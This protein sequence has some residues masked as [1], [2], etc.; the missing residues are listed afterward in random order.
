MPTSPAP[1][2]LNTARLVVSMALILLLIPEGALAEEGDGAATPFDYLEWRNIGPVNMSGRVA[3][4]EGVA[5]DPRIVYV[6]TASGGVWKTQDG[7]LSFKPIFDEQPIASIGDL[8]LAPS[9]PEVIYVG[10]GESNVRNSVSFG[11]GVYGSTDGGRSWTHL[12][13]D[14]T[15]HISR[16]L[17]HPRNPDLVYVGALG[18]IF[19]PNEERGVYRS[20]DGGTSW[21]K[22]LYLDDRH[23][24]AD[25]DIDPTN[26]NIL[27]ASMWHFQRRPWTMTSGSAE[28]G[29]YRSI[30]GGDTWEK[31]TEGLPKQMGRIGV[32][33]APSRPQVVYVIAESNE[34][35]LFRSEDRGASFRKVS[36]DVTI[37][38]R[39][40]YY[41]DLRV[42]PADENRIYAVASKLFRSIDGG[43]S[44][45]RISR[46][47]HIDFHSLWIDPQDPRRMWQG[48]DGGVAVSYDHGVTWEPVRNLPIAQFYQ[49]FAD[50]REP[51][52]Y[53]GGGLQDNGAW[54]GPSRTRE[55]AGI[56][57]DDWRM[58]SFGD[59][60]FVV[61]HPHQEELFISESQA[62]GILRTDMVTRRQIDISPQPRRNDGGPAAALEYRFNWNSP[63]IASPHDP[64]T[65][66]FAGNVVFKSEDFGDS[67]EVVSPDLTTDDPHK[68]GEAGGPVWPE[69]TTAE[70]HCT[71][72]SFA[73]SPA[74]PGVLWAGTDDGNLQISRDGGVSWSNVVG[75]VPGLPAHSPVS[76]VEPSRTAEGTAYAAFDRH[77]F[78]DFRPYIYRTTD[79][80]VTW[81]RLV[82][83]LPST[84]WVWVVREDPRRHELLYAGT[85][86]GLYVSSTGGRRWQRLHLGNLPTVAVHDVLI[87]PRE[88]DLLLGTH[89][90]GI[91]IFD[92]ATPIQE[93]DETIV[94]RPA[95]LFPVRAALRFPAQF[96][97]Y[98]LG[99]K[100]Y[101][102]PNPPAGAL[103][104]YYL[105]EKL[106]SANGDDEEEGAGATVA[107]EAEERIRIE[108]LNAEGE[109]I[110]TLKDVGKKA[111]LNRVAWG[112]C[113]DPPRPRTDAE[114]EPGDFSGPP[115]GPQV[116]PGTYTVRLTVDGQQHETSVEV[117]IDPLLKVSTEDLVAQFEVALKLHEW[118]SAVND[119]LRA[120]DVLQQQLEAR[121]AT[122]KNMHEEIPEELE[123]QWKAHE[124][125][126][127]EHIHVLARGE[128][129]PFWSQGPRLSDL[130]D[131]LFRNVDR[132]FA[133]PTAAQM[134]YFAELRGE[135]RDALAGLNRFLTE[136]APAFNAAL[137]RHRIPPLAVPEA[138]V[139]EEEK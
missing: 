91:W 4:V 86:L 74:Q 89:G 71:I 45:R 87:H 26:P 47:T 8:A 101:R 109:T 31:L 78:D 63:I 9:N 135:V 1:I 13:L 64:M 35:T 42:D 82:A 23:G 24:V 5:G 49:I 61:P 73:E 75:N 14:R 103:I 60:Y 76:H 124:E 43:A 129:K 57:S 79:F 134:D 137:E 123:T 99:D 30:D 56:L 53:V 128:E 136:A 85:E 48:Q 83:E 121:R 62:G 84:A 131:R 81:T 51:F 94:D 93:F 114:E 46:S 97:R 117:R 16:V 133:A 105:R 130:L 125:T 17:V 90:R 27:Y 98:G 34:G 126:I 19:A 88:N 58:M 12:G 10:T 120:L 40:F 44:F 37:V 139:P 55:P 69:N 132:A 20:G 122:L 68:Q 77:M 106:E 115:R 70:Y 111:G 18:H 15:R 107:T 113:Y 127:Q 108:I 104:T 6:G 96:T 65:V 110:R 112:L 7:G 50:D 52:Y 22:V 72:I 11:N 80:G 59:A 67:W 138:I 41:T 32:K 116:L 25:M 28:G 95:H 2:F 3:D 102:V 36:D 39:G 92:D 66:Y 33:V 38:S 119:G 118:R 54:Y 21:E 100:L 29:V